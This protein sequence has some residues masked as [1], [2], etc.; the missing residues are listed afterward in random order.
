MTQEIHAPTTTNC[1]RCGEPVGDNDERCLGCNKRV[2]PLRA[3]AYASIP[4]SQLARPAR[5]ARTRL[6][7]LPPVA[8]NSIAGLQRAARAAAE[9]ELEAV[10]ARGAPERAKRRALSAVRHLWHG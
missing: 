3:R 2:H 7:D 1:A 10:A 4:D 8:P 9:A 6:G 5:P